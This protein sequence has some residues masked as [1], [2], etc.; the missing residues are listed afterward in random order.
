MQPVD[1]NH[2]GVGFW[3][4]VRKG[5]RAPFY[6][7]RSLIC[8]LFLAI[9]A[10]PS[11][12]GAEGVPLAV[13]RVVR[14]D[15]HRT[16]R[17]QGELRPGREIDL[18][19]KVAGYL[20]RLHVDVGD[21]V[22]AGHL[23]GEL[24]MPETV[25]ERA[26]AMAVVRHHEEMLREAESIHAEAQLNYQRLAAIRSEDRRLVAGQEVEAARL[27]AQTEAAREASAARQLEVARA[28]LERLEVLSRYAHIVAPFSGVVT[29][30]Y[31]DEGALVQ[32]GTAS[33]IQAKPLLRLSKLQD[34]RLVFPLS[35]SQ[36]SRVERGTPL[37]LVLDDRGT[38]LNA[39]VARFSRRLDSATR[40]MLVEAD[41]DNEDLQLIPG[42][43][44]EVL[45]ELDRRA[46]TLVVPIEAMARLGDTRVHVLNKDSRLEV[47]PIQT[48]LETP[49]HIEVL[50][51]LE[52]G[53]LVQV[54]GWNQVEIGQVVRPKLLDFVAQSAH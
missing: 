37:E 14:M 44:V 36:A 8:L 2:I 4:D 46:D 22:E 54:G 32:A 9:L 6:R 16:V 52:E 24:E 35:M 38:R 42:M 43:F 26:K 33:S 13:S 23:L 15:L 29:K 30:R 5:F 11:V 47:R 20:Q 34:V 48:G 27:K 53:D 19:A 10:W 31:L 39:S 41:L 25:A 1:C 28:E 7:A 12:Q 50:N 21:R 45:V 51:G 49:T 17:V 18:H 3:R 40:T